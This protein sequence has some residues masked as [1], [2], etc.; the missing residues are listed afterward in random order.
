MMSHDWEALPSHWVPLDRLVYPSHD[1]YEE[2]MNGSAPNLS[3]GQP[4]VEQ[5]VDGSFFVHDGRHRIER[6]KRAGHYAIKCKVLWK[7]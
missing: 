5:L 6:A 2:H 7:W 3:H 4:W 1:M